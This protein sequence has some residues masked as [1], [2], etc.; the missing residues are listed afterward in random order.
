MFHQGGKCAGVT[1]ILQV[2]YGYKHKKYT[3]WLV[4][5]EVANTEKDLVECFRR[6]FGG[7]ICKVYDDRKPQYKPIY[8][9]TVSSQL[10]RTFLES[11]DPYLI[12]SKK[13]QAQLAIALQDTMVSNHSKPAGM[14]AFRSKLA[15]EIR[16]LKHRIA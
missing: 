14:E 11:I 9:W 2:N 3:Y 15:G 8:R 16:A 7:S 1:K 12:G 4:K 6:Q 13:K 5:V 10:A